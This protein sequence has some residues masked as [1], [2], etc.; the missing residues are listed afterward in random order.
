MESCV[1]RVSEEQTVE[2]QDEIEDN[3]FHTSL[4]KRT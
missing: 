1:R 4:V 3:I 2:S